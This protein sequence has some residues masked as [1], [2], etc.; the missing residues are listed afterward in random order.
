MVPCNDNPRGLASLLKPQ[1][2]NTNFQLLAAL[3]KVS[4]WP[5][6]CPAPAVSC[7]AATLVVAAV[8]LLLRLLQ[9]FA[10][11]SQQIAAKNAPSGR[12]NTMAL[13]DGMVPC[14]DI[15]RGLNVPSKTQRGNTM[16]LNDELEG[17][18]SYSLARSPLRLP[19]SADILL[20]IYYMYYCTNRNILYCC[21]RCR[22]DSFWLPFDNAES[23]YSTFGGAPFQCP[24]LCRNAPGVSPVAP[25]NGS[26]RNVTSVNAQARFK[27][28]ERH[29]N[30]IT[31]V[32]K[33]SI[34]GKYSLRASIH[35]HSHP[36]YP[37]CII[38]YTLLYGISI[39]F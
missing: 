4:T 36:F 11:F 10:T 33:A 14:N 25:V 17:R 29:P 21:H 6:C 30:H 34:H 37:I 2:K 8:L 39:D 24:F 5:S 15:P 22:N 12:E 9:L 28:K 20:S 27:R 23:I 31:K 32:T 13:R 26:H 16:P 18:M 7:S 38:Y 3:G 1:L 35:I 19:G